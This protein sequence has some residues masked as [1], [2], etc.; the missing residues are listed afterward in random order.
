MQNFVGTHATL[1]ANFPM[2]VGGAPV[3]DM[4]QP[5]LNM[6]RLR[7]VDPG[8][9]AVASAASLVAVSG[10]GGALVPLN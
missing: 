5:A 6:R 8:R 7:G 10:V 3:P 1:C 9:D 2:G 4:L